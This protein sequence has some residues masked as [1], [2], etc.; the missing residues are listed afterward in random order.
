MVFSLAFRTKGPWE[1]SLL[2]FLVIFL[3]TWAGGVWLSPI[4]PPIWG[5]H[6]LPFL[7]VALIFAILLVTAVAAPHRESTVELVDERKEEAKR[8]AALRGAALF[9]WVLPVALII[10]IAVRYFV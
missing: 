1:S 6:W 7:L 8:K 3:A 5:V 9:F 2:F 4:G 10:I